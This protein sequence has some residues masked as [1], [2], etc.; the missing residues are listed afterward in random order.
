ME[1]STFIGTGRNP[2]GPDIP[3]GLGMQL[4]QDPQAMNAF[5]RMSNAQK[6]ELIKY[7]QGASTG[8]DAKIRMSEVLRRLH[9]N[10]RIF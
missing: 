6:R 3:L 2:D 7:V 8:D 5:G 10:D 4:A 9:A 1:H